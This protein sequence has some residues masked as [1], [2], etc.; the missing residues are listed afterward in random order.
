MPGPNS[1]PSQYNGCPIKQPC[2]SDCIICNHFKAG[3][4]VISIAGQQIGF[5]GILVSSY[6]DGEHLLFKVKWGRDSH[7]YGKYAQH[8]KLLYD[9]NDIE[10]YQRGRG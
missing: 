6:T 8:Y 1:W 2:N 7:V 3:D 4:R 5:K 10:F 9:D